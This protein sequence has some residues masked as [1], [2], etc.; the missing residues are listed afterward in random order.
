MKKILIVIVILLLS[1]LLMALPEITFNEME[2]DFV[3]IKEEDGPV[4]YKFE[5]TNTGDEP[6]KLIRVKAT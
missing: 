4:E 6:L 2:H 3:T 1:N 5:F